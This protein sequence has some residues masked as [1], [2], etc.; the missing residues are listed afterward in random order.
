MNAHP[1]RAAG[2][3]S[4]GLLLTA[5][6]LALA[7]DAPSLPAR[8]PPAQT[9]PAQTPPTA[10]APSP[11]AAP[12]ESASP[13][14][15]PPADAPAPAASPPV[16]TPAAADVAPVA[17]PAE[18][19]SP[20]G[21]AEEAPNVS[22]EQVS[23]DEEAALSSIL[24]EASGNGG[25][26]LRFYGFMDFT[27]QD[28]LMSSDNPFYFAFEENGTFFIGNVNLY[29]DA[30]LS[31]RFRTLAE[32]RFLYLPHG[33][34]TSL[35]PEG[36]PRVST[37]TEDYAD[38]N[39]SLEWGGIEIERAWLDFRAYD[40]LTLRFG[41]Y[42]TPYGIWNV[43]HGSPVYVA[44]RRPYIIGEQLFPER[45]TGIQAW[46]SFV[47]GDST[48]GYH[49]TLSNGRGPSS[50]YRD[51]DG[52]KAVGGRLYWSHLGL[53]RFTL[54]ASAYH[55]DYTDRTNEPELVGGSELRRTEEIRTKYTETSLAADVKWEY[56]G[57]LVQA[58]VVHNQRAYDEA[59]RPRSSTGLLGSPTPGFAPDRENAGGYVLV[60]YRIAPLDLMPY[61]SGEYVDFGG[62]LIPDILTEQV[63]LNYQPDPAVVLKVQFAHARSPS[64]ETVFEDR[65]LTA[66]EG[67][68]AWT[69]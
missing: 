9:P 26:E 31:Q 1:R 53:G 46:G 58:E 23:L 34:D 8:T 22:Q 60:G 64:A 42:L 68:I 15:V 54:G 35:T 49:L 69:F 2:W 44:T 29:V 45:Q 48:L 57:L 18:P 62:T 36:A 19:A 52:N 59:G 38:V 27:Y 14:P 16:S 55:G 30:T 40:W 41:Q 28:L 20:G 32:V 43:D 51:L 56:E 12:A 67:Q 3:L 7:Q 11:A 5:S 61:V 66:V 50:A 13:A 63:G 17:E 33:T 4:L 47:L 39:R 24:A 25:P 37:S 10:P 6:S 21:T 65:N